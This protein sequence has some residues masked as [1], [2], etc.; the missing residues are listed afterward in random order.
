MF[1]A[2]S[3]L[4][5]S[6]AIRSSVWMFAVMEATHLVALAVF[7]GAILLVDL[8]LLGR[9]P[10]QQPVA[11]VARG[12]QPWL[13]GSLLVMLLT[14][15]PM[16]L[17][18]ALRYVDNTFFWWKMGALFLALVLTFTIRQRVAMGDDARLA[19]TWPKVVG[20]VSIIMWFGVVVG[21]RAI[22]FF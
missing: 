10:T 16:T 5:I 3:N 19:G 14:G 8:R 9:G 2:W 11:Q 6:V 21:G 12:T 20:L 15:V 17:A 1:T 7:M 22:G 4:P 18:N 13:L